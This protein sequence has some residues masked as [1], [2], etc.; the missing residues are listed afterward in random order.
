MDVA[1]ALGAAGAAT[2]TL[3][4][5]DAQSGG[6]G[7]AGRRWRSP[8][9]AGLWLTLLERPADASA[10]DVLSLR[11][12]LHAAEAVQPFAAAPVGLKW[13]ND[14]Y[15]GAGKL[16]GILV[17]ARWRDAHPEW[18]AIG[19]GLNVRAPAEEP[20]AAGLRVGAERLDVLAVLVP[21]LRRAAAARGALTAAE[22][23]RWAAR[24]LAAGRPVRA[25]VAGTV[26]G[27]TAAGAVRVRTAGGDERLVRQGSLEFA[28]G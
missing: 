19:F 18:V 10:L 1:H 8:S 20:Q 27:I 28:D 12:G 23:A 26:V 7:R 3:V 25:P 22:L 17:E 15:V 9:G 21:A 11:L 2:G 5:A 4:L 13:P 14:L 24:D 6:R 16:A